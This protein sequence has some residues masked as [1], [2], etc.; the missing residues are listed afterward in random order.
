MNNG[1]L[2]FFGILATLASSFWALL[3]APQLQIGSQQP[4]VLAS[5]GEYYPPARP[6]IAQ[7]GAEVYRSLG[8]AECHS[9]QVRQTGVEFDVWLTEPGTNKPAL[10]VALTQL[11]VA[12]AARVVEQLP[13]R[14]AHGLSMSAAQPI[15]AQLSKK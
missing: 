11:N 2:L 6:G 10:I 7:Q 14:V 3:L 12:D 1:P 8:C 13:L 9:R 15:A 4:L 5:T